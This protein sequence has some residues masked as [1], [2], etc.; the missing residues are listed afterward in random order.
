MQR[1]FSLLV[2]ACAVAFA[3]CNTMH[4][5]GK[6]IEKAGEAISGAAK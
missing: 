5:I 6:D 3:G 4:G 1:A 2:L